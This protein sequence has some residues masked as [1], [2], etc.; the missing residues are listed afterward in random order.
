MDDGALSIAAIVTVAAFVGVAVAATEGGRTARGGK[1]VDVPTDCQDGEGTTEEDQQGFGFSVP[2]GCQKRERKERNE[3]FNFNIPS[4]YNRK[5]KVS[6]R[7]RVPLLCPDPPTCC[8]ANEECGDGYYC[9][10]G[11]CQLVSTPS[12]T[13]VFRNDSYVTLLLGANGPSPVLP[14]EGG[15]TLPPGKQL[16]I[17]L[18][19]D[20]KQTAQAAQCNAAVFGPRFWARTGCNVGKPYWSIV[21]QRRDVNPGFV[22]STTPPPDNTTVGNG[23][24]PNAYLIATKWVDTSSKTIY[25]KS[26]GAK[27]VPLN[28][29]VY[30][31][32]GPPPSSLLGLKLGDYYQDT[33]NSRWY[34]YTQKSQ[35]GTGNCGDQYDCT[36]NSV[37][38][39]IPTSLA[40]FCFVCGNNNNFYDVS[41][42][43]GY[44]LSINI[45]SRGGS[46]TN[47]DNPDDPFWGITNLCQ[48]ERD[49]KSRDNGK[50][51]LH[52][53]QLKET[54]PQEDDPVVG[55][56]SNCGY[57]AYPA[58]PS[59]DCD[60][61]DERCRLWKQFCCQ[62]ASSGK[63]CVV[64]GDCQDSEACWN[65]TCQCRAFYVCQNPE[66]PIPPSNPSSVNDEGQWDEPRCCPEGICFKN[67]DPAAQPFSGGCNR[68]ECIGDDTLHEVCHKA[69]SWPNDPTTFTTNAMEFVITFSPGGSDYPLTRDVEEIPLC[70]TLNPTYYYDYL[71]QQHNCDPQANNYSYTCAIKRSDQYPSP[72]NWPCTVD[73]SGTSCQGLGTLCRWG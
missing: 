30:I 43:D 19:E 29:H 38:G 42:V 6:S 58:A 72:P 36:Y 5:E 4:N 63:E 59:I 3:E 22:Q 61:A 21:T 62:S 13:I 53:N 67:R 12:I 23:V 47:P 24:D 10:D 52:N 37:A 14:V 2:E 11:F 17:T 66:E 35:C 9:G 32:R 15:W 45:E 64:D 16:T 8:T 27:W 31:L 25:Y 46:P 48:R 55:V 18:P 44:N 71:P 51:S 70:S 33:N 20:W 1:H 40:E 73:N 34:V 56:F 68:G 69:Y 65:G 60:P 41:I 28:Q 26:Y 39:Q 7:G 50:F 57:Y 54:I 49:L